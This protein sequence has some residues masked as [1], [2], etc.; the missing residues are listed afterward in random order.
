MRILREEEGEKLRFSCTYT[1]FFVP[2][3]AIVDKSGF[4]FVS[5][6]GVSHYETLC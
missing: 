5:L 2:L 4:E 6:M 3:Q 1:F